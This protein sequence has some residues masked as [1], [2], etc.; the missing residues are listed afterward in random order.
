MSNDEQPLHYVC[1]R[2]R[3][4]EIVDSRDKFW[5]SSCGCRVSRGK[6][7][8]S[9]VDVC[10]EFLP[11]TAAEGAGRR[12]A[13]RADVEAI[14]REAEEKHLVTRPFRDMATKSETE[15]IC[16]CCDDCCGYFIDPG[17]YACDKGEKIEKTDMA[18]CTHCGLC[19]DVCYFGARKMVG[20]ELILHRDACY[21]CGL[22]VDVC[23]E[24]CIELVSR[25]SEVSA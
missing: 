14:L 22:C 20:G 24:D 2:E 15:G 3:A 12:E 25:S 23:P 6:C 10:L 21:G 16:F 8:R 11:Q 17:G 19:A 9:R 18:K 5:V 13:S 1:T 4:R 7:E